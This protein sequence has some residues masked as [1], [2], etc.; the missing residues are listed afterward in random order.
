MQLDIDIS[1]PP[2]TSENPVEKLAYELLCQ[3]YRSRYSDLSYIEK[4]D[5]WRVL[6][7]VTVKP[8]MTCVSK[9]TSSALHFNRPPTVAEFELLAILY[10]VHACANRHWFRAYA[11]E[12]P[13]IFEPRFIGIIAQIGRCELKNII[14]GRITM[15]SISMRK[16]PFGNH[17]GVRRGP[18]PPLSRG[19]VLTHS[20]IETNNPQRPT[21]ST[22]DSGSTVPESA[23]PVP[24][25]SPAAPFVEVAD[26]EDSGG[27]DD[28]I[29]AEYVEEILVPSREMT[30][31]ADSPTLNL[32][33]VATKLQLFV[34]Q[35]TTAVQNL[36]DALR[37]FER[38]LAWLGNKLEC[39]ETRNHGVASEISNLGI[40]HYTLR[41]DHTELQRRHAQLCEVIGSSAT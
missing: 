18:R 8:S 32:E 9:H 25:N 4:D 28:T 12:H 37:S 27:E 7:K 39:M 24:G 21:P 30:I 19:A 29:K 40:S 11:A 31:A 38:K 16:I 26:S 10:G 35:S 17:R 1:V 3:E 5:F 2:D 36:Q 20:S 13:E 6:Q 22:H 33:D 15:P 23:P 14:Q 34:T 41:R